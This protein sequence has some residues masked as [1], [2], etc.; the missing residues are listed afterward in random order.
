MTR[1]T[2]RGIAKAILE[3]L[4]G[5]AAR[6]RQ[7][8]ARVRSRFRRVGLWGVPLRSSG[9]PFPP[10]RS[11]RDAEAFERTYGEPYWMPLP[12]QRREWSE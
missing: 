12:S 8:E 10:P 1:P 5:T 6:N 3:S 4:D 7:I 2:L 11:Y 9:E